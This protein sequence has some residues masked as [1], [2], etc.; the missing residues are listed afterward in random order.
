MLCAR[1]TKQG[2]DPACAQHCMAAVIKHVRL[3]DLAK[4][5]D[6]PRMVR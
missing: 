4:E 6:K 1:W 5:I 3:E 2:L